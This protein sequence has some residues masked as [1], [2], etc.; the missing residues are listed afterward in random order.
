MFMST[1]IRRIAVSLATL[2]GAAATVLAPLPA[3]QAATTP[4]LDQLSGHAANTPALVVYPAQ[5][6]QIRL[7]TSRYSGDVCKGLGVSMAISRTDLTGYKNQLANDNR[8]TGTGQYFGSRFV[9]SPNQPGTWMLRQLCVTDHTRPAGCRSFTAANSPTK[10]TIKRESFLTGTPHG[11]AIT[12]SYVTARL[13]AWSTVG[14]MANLGNQ[15]VQLQVRKP[16]STT[17]TTIATRRMNTIGTLGF[18]VNW[19]PYHRYDVRLQYI[20]PY[21]TIASDWHYLGRIA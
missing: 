9:L 20:S 8:W 21:Q 10:V 19:S 7:T 12:H 15:F 11:T 13:Q 14:T 6:A 3:A 16:G 1:I 17:Y 4:C 2:A 5:P 18:A